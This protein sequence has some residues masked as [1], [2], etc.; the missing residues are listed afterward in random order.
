[1]KNYV[2]D[3]EGFKDPVLRCD[4]C[5]KIVLLDIIHKRKM[6]NHCG[7]LRF[8]VVSNFSEEELAEMKAK[9]IDP[10]FLALF[11]EVPD[12]S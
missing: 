1:M 4:S 3:P 11:E 5:A 6:C 2:D 10:D 8:R 12:E 9:N 7:N